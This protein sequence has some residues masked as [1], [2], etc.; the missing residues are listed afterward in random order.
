VK[1]VGRVALWLAVITSLIIL[2]CLS[3]VVAGHVRRPGTT[4]RAGDW[5]VLLLPVFPPL[6][7]IVGWAGMR[8]GSRAGTLMRGFLTGVAAVSSVYIV[9][10]AVY[11][12][13]QYGPISAD[14]TAYWS[15]LA[16][17]AFWLWLP[18]TAVGA[19]VGMTVAAVS[20]R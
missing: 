13:R 7:T 20:T 3:L 10:P 5:L 15:L 6:V 8:W 1:T 19:V 4:D 9:I 11:L 17:P 14:G 12:V 2:L 18:A 16:I